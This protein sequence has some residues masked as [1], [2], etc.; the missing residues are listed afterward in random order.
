M[1]LAIENIKLSFDQYQRYRMVADLINNERS[2]PVMN[3][4]DIGSGPVDISEFLPDDKIT[5][6]DTESRS[7]AGYIC[8]SALDM[9]FRGGSFDMVI[10]CDMYEHIRPDER[11]TFLDELDRVSRESFII[12]CPFSGAGIENAE[13]MVNSFYKDLFGHEHKWLVEHRETGLPSLKHL[14]TWIS[15]KGYG[16]EVLHNGSL[17]TWLPMMFL[18]T[19]L[20]KQSEWDIYYRLNNIYVREIYSGD[21]YSPSYRNMIVVKKDRA[22]IKDTHMFGE[23]HEKKDLSGL[24]LTSLCEKTR[25]DAEVLFNV[26]DK[27]DERDA[28]KKLVR[29]IASSEFLLRQFK[30]RVESFIS[31]TRFEVDRLTGK[32]RDFIEPFKRI[33]YDFLDDLSLRYRKGSVSAEVMT[34]ILCLYIEAKPDSGKGW[35]NLGVVLSESGDTVEAKYAF[36]NACLLDHPAA[37]RNLWHLYMTLQDSESAMKVMNEGLKRTGAFARKSSAEQKHNKH[38]AEGKRTIFR[39]TRKVQEVCHDF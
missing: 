37:Y 36:F 16:A 9:P 25:E 12:A 18:G 2:K 26:M 30:D 14:K 27:D 4:L 31:G 10:S 13:A 35:N 3:I 20:E 21:H 8:G 22:E 32:L 6:L 11:E 23:T 1:R 24:I 33:S 39:Y 38:P 29:S 28:I 34:K 17:D 7:E 5:R 15:S 19:Y